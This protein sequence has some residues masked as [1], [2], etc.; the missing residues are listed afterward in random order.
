MGRP[1]GGVAVTTALWAVM[2][3]GLELIAELVNSKAPGAAA[4][5]GEVIRS[6]LEGIHGKTSPEVILAELES[7]RTRL[8]A[9]DEEADKALHDRF[10]TTEA[11]K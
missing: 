6:L 9:N 4:G 10:D 2:V 7:L 3:E 5:V 11:T 1:T 8:K